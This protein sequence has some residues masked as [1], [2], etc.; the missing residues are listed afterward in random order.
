MATKRKISLVLA[1]AALLA[2]LAVWQATVLGAVTDAQNA[3][4]LDASFGT[5]GR[6]TTDFGGYYDIGQALAIHGNGKT[7]VAG[8]NQIGPGNPGDF[9]VARYNPDGSLDTAFNGTGKATTDFGNSDDRG[10]GVAIQPNGKIVVVGTSDYVNE[11]GM[12]I[13]RYRAD[14]L[15]DPSFGGDGMVTTPLQYSHGRAVA[16]Q[17]DNRILVAGESNNSFVLVRLDS[18]GSLDSTF[19]TN[20]IATTT[21][22]S[23]IGDQP[24][25]RGIDIRPDGKIVIAGGLN[26]VDTW[27]FA[28]LRYNSDGSLDLGFNGTGIATTAVGNTGPLGGG[29][30]FDVALQSDDKIVAAGYSHNGIHSDITLIRHNAD[31]SLDSTFDGDGIVITDYGAAEEGHAVALQ[32]NGKIV[33]AAHLQEDNFAV[34]RYNGNGSLDLDFGN[35]GVA[36]TSF[37][38]SG[39]AD[40]WDIAL[41]TDGKIIAAGTSEPFGGA[42]F[43]LARFVG[44]ASSGCPS[45]IQSVGS[46]HWN[47]ARTWNLGR[48]PAGGDVVEILPGHEVIGPSSANV[49][50]LCN[51]GRLR[52]ASNQPLRIQATG[53][54]SNYHEILSSDGSRGEGAACGG[55]GAYLELQG[56]PIFNAGL[57]QAGDGG[58]GEQCGGSGGSAMVLGRNT[59]NHGTICA[60]RGGNVLGTTTGQGGKGGDAHIWGKWSGAGSL[61]NTGLACG[62]DGGDGNSNAIGVQD[63]GAGGRLKLISLPSV[64]LGSGQ[65]YAGRGGQGSGGGADGLDGRVV[66]EPNTISLAGIS[67]RVWGGNV[68][69]FGG[70]DWVLDLSG[71]S[72]GSIQASGSITLAVGLSGTVDLRGNTGQVLQ[73]GTESAAEGH[74][75]LQSGAHV[76]IAAD[77]ILLDPGVDLV[78]LAGEN[79]VTAPGT[80]LRDVSWAGPHTART[81]PGATVPIEFLVM[82]GGPEAD[83]YDLDISDSEGWGLSTLPDSVSVG[84]LE[85]AE[86]VLEVTPPEEEGS[87]LISIVLTSQSDPKLVVEEQ[88]HVY[89]ISLER[90]YLPLVLK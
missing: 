35:N 37:D 81:T 55:A 68:L 15:L 62:G 71:M 59:T 43:A 45:T 65:H 30:A 29:I 33:M 82:N 16:L 40:P 52:G 26:N 75:I 17:P 46:G 64:F 27:E 57:V 86:L 39:W 74:G 44:D 12:A 70:D 77:T 19:G 36:A 23:T 88:I 49:T 14:G 85:A 3:G 31:G 53:F 48:A 63:G 61:I 51:Y 83:T 8:Y 79:V 89:A 34:L 18:D 25:V 56:S 58:A 84:G 78:E 13:V 72:N 87:D 32:P 54:I 50:G 60:G 28:V 67:T 24:T 47:N 21:V 41:Q 20:G 11:P 22:D 90:I 38:A 10:N 73:P 1:L 6:V 69:V 5:A 9:A 80:I 4:D 66:I 2:L 76:Y 42:D 7:V